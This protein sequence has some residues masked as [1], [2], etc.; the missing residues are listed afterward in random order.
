VTEGPTNWARNITFGADRLE[1]PTS[2]EQL[3]DLVASSDR[4]RAL[5]S[6]HSFS[7]IADTPG[8]LV[9][10]AGLPEHVEI[11]AEQST[12]TVSAGIRYTH[13]CRR[14]H[15]N[16]YALHNLGSLPHISVAGSCATATHGSGDA[17]GNLATAVSAIEMVTADGSLVT[18]SRSA[19]GDLFEGAVV[20]LGSL[21][22]VTSLTL[23]VQ[24]A[25]DV[26]QRVY[27][28][29]PFDVLVERFDEIFAGGYSVSVFTDWRRSRVDKVWVKRRADDPRDAVATFM[30]AVP[31]DAARHPVPGMP[32]GNCTEQM[33]VPGPWHERLPHFRPD[34]TPSSGRELQSEYLVPRR[35]AVD[36][37]DAM[38]RTGHRVAPVLQIAEL[39][40]VAS[41]RLWMSPSYRR[42]VMGIH[43]TWIHDMDAV[44][45]VVGLV[46][47][48]LA[49]FDA[50]PHWGKL[51]TVPAE[52]VRALYPRL[53]DFRELVNAHDPDGKF[54][55]AFVDRYLLDHR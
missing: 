38:R 41:D 20:G 31:T 44:L 32:A 3:Q 35:H 29:L 50:A 47:R 15:A 48:A 9:S 7:D 11:D 1:A 17:N 33:G 18:L 26:R 5:G 8:V 22:I 36:A 13:L 52:V 4:L 46:E 51:S 24:P 40:T 25:F 6:G 49:S 21:G 37:L 19:D 43:F 14:L 27:E 30:G 2:V 42:D 39:R 23:D 28:G 45:P 10:L 55:N 54:R 34:F 12:A 53:G 16:S